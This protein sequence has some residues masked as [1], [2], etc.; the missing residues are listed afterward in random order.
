MV[1]DNQYFSPKM[2][3]KDLQDVIHAQGELK[4]GE[5][6]T[7]SVALLTNQDNITESQLSYLA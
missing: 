1:I 4:P 7:F 3:L 5:E 2:H 6:K